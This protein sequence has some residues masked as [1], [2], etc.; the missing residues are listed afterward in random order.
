MISIAFART[1]AATNREQKRT[2]RHIVNEGTSATTTR[3]T[4]GKAYIKTRG[5]PELANEYLYNMTCC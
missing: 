4:G 5:T 3:S 1:S 2:S